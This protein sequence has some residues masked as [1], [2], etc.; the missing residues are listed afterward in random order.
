MT[1]VTHDTPQHMEADTETYDPIRD[2]LAEQF[3][4]PEL[5]D[6]MEDAEARLMASRLLKVLGSLRG[7]S[8][9]NKA[10][11]NVT[12]D[13]LMN[14]HVEIENVIEKRIDWVTSSLR[15]LFDTF[16]TVPHGKQSLNL[17]G[18]RIGTKKQQPELG[19]SS[20]FPQ[21][22]YPSKEVEHSKW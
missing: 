15:H 10:E 3:D 21:S 7:E 9:A 6:T 16:M 12:K 19:N 14:R 11:Y 13:F 17:L 8:D 4:L 20:L 1:S 5:A 2:E 22:T 18:G